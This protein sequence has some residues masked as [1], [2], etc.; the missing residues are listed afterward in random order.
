MDKC[1]EYMMRSEYMMRYEGTDPVRPSNQNL[2]F[3]DID[4]LT[5]VTNTYKYL[6]YSLVTPERLVGTSW[7]H[8]EGW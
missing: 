1:Q 6:K 7:S 2:T 5:C 4:I 3:S 8:H